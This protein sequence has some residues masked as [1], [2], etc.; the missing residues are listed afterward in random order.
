MIIF[1]IKAY[2][3]VCVYCTAL[4]KLFTYC[5]IFPYIP[6]DQIIS[7]FTQITVQNHFLNQY[8]VLFYIKNKITIKYIEKNWQSC[9]LRIY[10]LNSIYP[11]FFLNWILL[12]TQLIKCKTVTWMQC[13]SL[14]IKASAKCINV[15][16]NVLTNIFAKLHNLYERTV[17]NK[18]PPEPEPSCPLVFLPVKQK[19]SELGIHF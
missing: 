13:K 9:L 6:Q 4:F 18:L 17:N 1:L 16:V 19:Q 5:N 14:W 12:L 10:I 11:F 15:N 7:E 2:I 8:F 3:S